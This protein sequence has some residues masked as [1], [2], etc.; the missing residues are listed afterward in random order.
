[1]KV[2]VPYLIFEVNGKEY[3]IDAYFSKKLERIE[4]PVNTVLVFKFPTKNLNEMKC[5]YHL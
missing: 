1:M 3:M 4:K 2:E 5:K